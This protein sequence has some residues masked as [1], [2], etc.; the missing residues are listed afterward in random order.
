VLQIFFGNWIHGID[1]MDRKHIS[2]ET[3][4]LL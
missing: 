4:A 1:H 2:V 3:I